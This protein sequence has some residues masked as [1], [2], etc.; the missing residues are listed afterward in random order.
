MSQATAAAAGSAER[1][2]K[3]ERTRRRILDTAL[4]LFA[5][6]G[7]EATTMRLIAERAEVSL[8]SSY[9]YFESKEH[10]VH[11]LYVRIEEETTQAAQ[12]L[13]AV[14]R[15]LHA[16]L[17]GVLRASLDVIEPY[18]DVAGALFRV[19]ADPES[20]LNPFGET[21]RAVRERSIA[22]MEEAVT[23]ARDRLPKD[24]AAELPRLLWLFHMGVILLWVHDRTPGQRRTRKAVEE[25]LELIMSLLQMATL[26]LMRRQRRKLL[27]LI[28]TIAA[29]G[30]TGS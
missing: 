14:E 6:R 30:A 29:P 22:L 4:G 10:L 24:V 18:H 17:L 15:D 19:A 8:G 3:G 16:R 1:I 7:Y 26:P 9:H 5:E 28:A 20:P 11:A 23:G 12:E 13:L 2:P 25:A 21:S 27:S